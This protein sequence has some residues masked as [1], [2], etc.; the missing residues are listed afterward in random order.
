MPKNKAVEDSLVFLDSE[1]EHFTEA[2]KTCHMIM[3]NARNPELSK[4]L[5]KYLAYAQELRE[6]R[7]QVAAME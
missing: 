4:K 6:I 3:D 1:I 7:D 2:A 5:H